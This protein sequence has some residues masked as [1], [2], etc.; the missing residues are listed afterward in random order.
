MERNR[1]PGS[2]IVTVGLAA[3]VYHS[4][5][6]PD[7]PVANDAAELQRIRA[8]HETVWLVYT[9]PAQLKAASPYLWDSIEKNFEVVKTF[10]GSL[11]G[12]QVV[13]C[14]DRSRNSYPLAR[15]T[16]DAKVR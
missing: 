15:S 16:S 10:P 14:R 4:Y 8:A 5:V 6:S 7:W 11:G 9:L 3:T 1:Q 2:A 13:V 12:G